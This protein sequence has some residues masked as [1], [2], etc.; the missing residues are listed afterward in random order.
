MDQHNRSA[1]L[2]QFFENPN[3]K[4]EA[5]DEVEFDFGRT[6]GVPPW[7]LISIG[8]HP[9]QLLEFRHYSIAGQHHASSTHRKNHSNYIYPSL[10]NTHFMN[11]LI[12]C[13]LLVRLTLT[14]WKT[15]SNPPWMSC[16]QWDL[17]S[18]VYYQRWK[19]LTLWLL[20][21]PI[22]PSKRLTC[23]GNAESYWFRRR[24][25][26][27]KNQPWEHNYCNYT[28]LL[29]KHSCSWFYSLA[30]DLIFFLSMNGVWFFN[31][32]HWTRGQK[33]RITEP[34]KSTYRYQM[35]DTCPTQSIQYIYIYIKILLFF[36][37]EISNGGDSNYH[38]DPF[39]HRES[40]KQ[41]TNYF[42]LFFLG[43]S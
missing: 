13:V 40:E 12:S 1:Q 5:R 21:W 15:P 36:S 16:S 3:P 26:K 25:C 28:V 31:L 43:S 34:R 29:V 20:S 37:S 35:F 18:I 17:Q 23:S 39:R 8:K 19:I 6:N 38:G 7:L 14:H 24:R 32:Q 11:S 2:S 10:I 42:S 22:W 4:S 9:C 41:R 33:Y 30:V 27:C